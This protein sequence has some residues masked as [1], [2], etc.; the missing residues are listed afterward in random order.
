MADKNLEL[1]LRIVAEATGKQNLTALVNELRDIEQ[2]ADAANPAAG[3]LATELDDLSDQSQLIKAFE[4][5]KRE[6]SEQETAVYA[7]ATA[8]QK[9]QNEAKDTNKPFVDVARSINAAEKDLTELRSELSKNSTRHQALQQQLERTGADTKNLV[10]RKRELAAS[11]D[12]TAKKITRFSSN[13]QN[14]SRVQRE[15]AASLKGV[16]AQVTALA[17]AYVGFDRVAQAVTNIFKTGDKFEKLGLQMN[18]L[19]GS[20]EGGEKATA[21]VEDFT[22]NTPLQLGEVSQAFVKLKA[23]GLDPMNGT[24]A[25]IT[26]TALKLGGGFQEVEG[27]SLALGQAWAKQKLQG[28]EILQLVERGVPVWDL[29]QKATG[30]NVQELQKLSSAGKLGRDVIQQLIDEMGK[31]STGSAAAQMALFSG[32]VSNAKDNMEQFYKLIAESGVMEW[33]KNQITDLNNKFKQMSE[34]GSLKEWAQAISDNLIA[35]GEAITSAGAALYEYRDE[36][37]LVAKAWLA[38]KVGSFFSNVI[39]GSRAAIVS[40]AQYRAAV[41]TST[42]ATNQATAAAKRFST[43][44][45]AMGRAGL[46][47]LLINE[48][49]KVGG[50]YKDLLVMQEAAEKAQQNAKLAAAELA[51]EFAKLSQ[52]TGVLVTNNNEL[53]AAVKAGKIAW[54]EAKGSYYGVVLEQEKLARAT[55]EA[56]AAERQRQELMTL[57]LP[58]ALN[59]I[60]T[61]EQQA[62]SLSGVRDGVD[63]FIRSIDAA[64]VALQGAGAQY[65]NQLLI[66][67]NLKAKFVEHN[68]SLERQAFLAGDVSKAYQELGLTSASVLEETALKM[69]GAFELIQQSNE[70]VTAQQQ[71]FLKWADAA[72][73]ASSATDKTVPSSVQAAAAALGLTKELDKLVAAAN[74]LKPAID[75]DSAVVARFKAEVEKTSEAIKI[76]E[77]VLASSTATTEQK[78]AAQKAL[79]VQEARLIEQEQDLNKVRALEL[80]TMSELQREQAALNNELEKLN[81]QYQSGALEAAEYAAEKERVGNMLSV[82]NGL[83]GDFKN[84]Q[85]DATAATK[86][87]TAATKEQARAAESASRS[88]QK[89]KREVENLASAQQ[90]ASRTV[91][92]SGGASVNKI[93]QYQL[94][95]P[96]T[97]GFA[98][99]SSRS[100][101]AEKERLHHIETQKRQYK[102]FESSISNSNDLA[103]LNRL[104]QRIN[105]QLTYIDSTQKGQLNQL[106]A[107]KAQA[108]K[109]QQRAKNEAMLA[110]QREIGLRNLESARKQREAQ[111]RRSSS[112][113]NTSSNASSSA[114]R[115]ANNKLSQSINKLIDALNFNGSEKVIRLQLALPDGSQAELLAKMEEAFIERLEQLERS[116]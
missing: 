94:N 101:Q 100:I 106:I 56:A 89:Q 104:W 46:Y 79:L 72:V 92:V 42:T 5:S 7:A 40:L 60:Q 65:A 76:N 4:Q 23:F 107:E 1:A 3:K 85:D 96:S 63:G 53:E 22:R 115:E 116:Q 12:K 49:I 90:R 81:S 27:I 47:T 95:N 61:L 83:L 13:L 114:N 28:E 19:M 38:L 93:A 70:P 29:L 10:A 66:L 6:I 62:Q 97:T 103:S 59:V 15:Q 14:G 88:L 57:S 9:L 25:A 112:N 8:L 84:A 41:A 20:L 64:Q 82:V 111:T 30:K 78:T 16:V 109:E 77:Q 48:T 18:A 2:S 105:K 50:A 110:R 71:A 36:I 52:Q 45:A 74:K 11:Y 43:A 35:A 102:N 37:A 26:D 67:D 99:V 44:A 24:L 58:Q 91:V 108:L 34:D 98:H 73:K 17:A 21:W 86:R 113:N 75:T 54:D 51:D 80:Q 68:A 33:L 55:K 39:A 32:Q 69:Q 87:G 31:A